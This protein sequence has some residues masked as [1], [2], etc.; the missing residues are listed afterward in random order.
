MIA[1]HTGDFFLINQ[2]LF[3]YYT[4]L[5]VHTQVSRKKKN[6]WPLTSG[7]KESLKKKFQTKGRTK[8]KGS[9]RTTEVLRNHSNSTG[10]HVLEIQTH[11]FIPSTLTLWLP[12]PLTVFQ[13]HGGW[14]RVFHVCVSHTFKGT[15]QGKYC[16]YLPHLRDRETEAPGEGTVQ[17]TMTVSDICISAAEKGTRGRMLGNQAAWPSPRQQMPYTPAVR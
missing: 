6:L 7:Y 8:A 5:Q 9:V 10:G 1:E 3:I 2:V 13:G 17:V 12:W 15:L 4:D 14:V 16:H 11:D